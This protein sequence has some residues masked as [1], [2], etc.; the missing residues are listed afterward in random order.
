[1]AVTAVT[2]TPLVTGA[3]ADPFI[4][5]MPSSE[6]STLRCYTPAY[7]FGIPR[8]RSGASFLPQAHR[9]QTWRTA[10]VSEVTMEN[11]ESAF[12]GPILYLAV[13]WA[14][15]TVIFMS[16]MIWRTLLTSHEDDQI[17]LSKGEDYLAREQ[18]ELI[19]KITRLAPPIMTTGIASGGLLL[20]IV[21]MYVY[22]GL[23]HF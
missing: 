1:V 2:S 9:L 12:T 23:K 14:V 10:L 15:I 5:S 7:R 6:I 8:L 17:F 22:Q 18:R 16:L 20:L 13:A 19:A 3:T 21:G 4:L 11:L